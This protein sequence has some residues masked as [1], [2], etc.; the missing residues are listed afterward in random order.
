MGGG[1]ALFRLAVLLVQA[2]AVTDA[3]GGAEGGGGDRESS[4]KGSG[5]GTKH[6]Y[7]VVGAGPAGVQL[8]HLLNRAGMDYAVFE[9]GTDFHPELCCLFLIAP[10]LLKKKVL[11]HLSCHTTAL[12]NEWLLQ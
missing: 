8:G 5:C 9:R 12:L 10:S 4:C 1:R 6:K 3:A 11:L 2:A 7:C